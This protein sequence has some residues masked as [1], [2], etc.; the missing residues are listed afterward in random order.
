MPIIRRRLSPD[1]V[2]PSDL[3]YDAETDT[4]QRNVNGDWLDSPESDPRH[5]TTFPPRITA[6]TECD[7]AQ[8]VTDALKNQV[9]QTITAIDN[10]S[11]L[12]TIAGIILSL[13]TFGTFG[14]FISL[15]LTAADYMVGVGSSALEAALTEPVWEQI[16]CILFCEMG[17]TGRL[18]ASGLETVKNRI[19]D[20]IGGVAAVTINQMLTIAGEGGIN[21]LAALGTSTGDCSECDACPDEWCFT[22]DFTLSQF[23]WD[24]RNVSPYGD[25]G[26]YTVGVG[27]QQLASYGTVDNCTIEIDFAATNLIRVTVEFDPNLDGSNPKTTLYLN[28]YG[29]IFAQHGGGF[30]V[31][32]DDIDTTADFIGLDFDPYQGDIQEWT[33][34][35]TR[36]T[37]HGTGENPFGTD[38]C[39]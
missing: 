36:I 30:E 27:Y 13:F 24:N 35:L 37:I 32:F 19:T 12:F 18:T 11:T 38:N 14:V 21:N 23:G 31:V 10:A 15:A 39:E 16:K 1:T 9:E 25:I 3:R 22:F 33:G 26:R 28:S 29:A 4:V 8:S 6:A 20:E 17:T 5:Q 7:A 34:A 2:Y